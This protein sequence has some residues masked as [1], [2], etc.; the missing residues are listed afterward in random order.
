VSEPALDEK[1]RGIPLWLV[2]DYLRQMG[3]R[4]TADGRFA[5]DGWTVRLS[6]AEDFTL[7]SLRVGQVRLEVWGALEVVTPFRA[8]LAQ[9]LM[10]G[11]G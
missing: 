8:A 4:E 2:S 11:G 6:Q 10:R 5:G 3:A 1:L 9:R 7:G